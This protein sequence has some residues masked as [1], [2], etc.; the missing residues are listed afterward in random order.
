MAQM[1]PKNQG[2]A[3]AFA[4]AALICQLLTQRLVTRQTE[5]LSEALAWIALPFLV[6]T[7]RP[8]YPDEIAPPVAASK[9]ASSSGIFGSA[10]FAAGIAVASFCR[11][12]NGTSRFYVSVCI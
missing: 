6:R 12:E 7:M 8:R 10:I 3:V 4:A 11:A 2:H 5:L 9:G 1:R